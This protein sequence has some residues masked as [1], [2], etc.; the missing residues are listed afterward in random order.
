[1][2]NWRVG[3]VKITRVVEMLIPFPDGALFREATLEVRE[4]QLFVPARSLSGHKR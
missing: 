2:L 4:P 3:A 1:M